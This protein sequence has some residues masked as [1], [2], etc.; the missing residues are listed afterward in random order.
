LPAELPPT[1]IA[2]ADEPSVAGKL[3][4][5]FKADFLG[6]QTTV[7]EERPLPPRELPPAPGDYDKF[8]E[9]GLAVGVRDEGLLDAICNYV[10]SGNIRDLNW[11][12]EALASMHLPKDYFPRWFRLWQG[13]LNLAIPQELAKRIEQTPA[14]AWR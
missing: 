1:A 9:L 13:Q 14:S 6:L 10:I 2:K 12:W 4:G 11:V 7:E 5:A 3:P 8:R